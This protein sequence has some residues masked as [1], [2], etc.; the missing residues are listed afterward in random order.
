MWGS[1]GGI[2]NLPTSYT[3]D[4]T[5]KIASRRELQGFRTTDCQSETAG[6]LIF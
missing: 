1:F 4:P 2:A 5:G 3:R 6:T